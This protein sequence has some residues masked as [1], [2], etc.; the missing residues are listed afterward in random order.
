MLRKALTAIRVKKRIIPF[1][2]P[3]PILRINRVRVGVIPIS[4]EAKIQH[5]LLST[6]DSKNQLEH[7]NALQNAVNEAKTAAITLEQQSL[8]LKNKNIR[9]KVLSELGSEIESKLNSNLEQI[10]SLQ[11]VME[12]ID[13]YCIPILSECNYF[14]AAYADSTF[15]YLNWLID[16]KLKIEG[17]DIQS[18][19]QMWQ[20][21]W[22]SFEIAR[23]EHP[24]FAPEQQSAIE[25]LSCV[26]RLYKDFNHEDMSKLK[27]HQIDLKS[28]E[29]KLKNSYKQYIKAKHDKIFKKLKPS[30]QQNMLTAHSY[31]NHGDC[32]AIQWIKHDISPGDFDRLADEDQKSLLT[33]LYSNIGIYALRNNYFTVNEFLSLSSNT[34]RDLLILLPD[35][36]SEKGYFESWRRRIDEI[37]S[38]K[39]FLKI[40]SLIPDEYRNKIA[41]WEEAACALSRGGYEAAIKNLDI[42]DGEKSKLVKTLNVAQPSVTESPVGIRCVR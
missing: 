28:A 32:D 40:F 9:S 11:E 24:K 21:T 1:V 19:F 33:L 6:L 3:L 31:A 38:H 15:T 39:D 12:N 7:T 27:S 36:E 16:Y 17:P 42:S 2:N 8:L 13:L 22:H 20:N 30:T 26:T 34:K 35:A 25:Y 29:E 18:I 23:S 10:K 41:S 37:F 5:R 4:S 14:L